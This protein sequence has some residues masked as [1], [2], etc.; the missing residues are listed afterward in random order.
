[1]TGLLKSTGKPRFGF[2][3]FRE[4]WPPPTNLA[5]SGSFSVE[6]Y[7]RHKAAVVARIAI[8]VVVLHGVSASAFAQSTWVGTTSDWNIP[9]NW[10][11]VGVPTGTAATFNTPTPS[12]STLITSA[13]SSAA[14]TVPTLSFN[15][16]GYTLSLAS[17]FSIGGSGILATAANAPNF[18]F[19]S[20]A[21]GEFT[22]SSTA[23][24]AFINV[25]G[26]GPL[27]A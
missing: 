4:I 9:D 16:P 21:G 23:G 8:A 25:N 13:P 7:L 19:P 3:L 10:N 5:S 2:G 26:L 17:G 27:G 6:A 18:P 1:M 20:G 24:P 12:T 11:P 22:G 15:A 14:V